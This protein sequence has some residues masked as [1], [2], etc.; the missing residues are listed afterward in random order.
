MTEQ[1]VEQALKSMKVGKAPGPSGVTSNL[2]KA[3][4]ATGVKGLFQ[5]CEF[6]EQKGEVPEQ[7]AKSY[8][9]LVYK[10]KGAVLMED[11]YED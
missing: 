6:I 8:T 7:W 4:G 2:I 1:I 3:A 10:C 11:K 5:V 9:I